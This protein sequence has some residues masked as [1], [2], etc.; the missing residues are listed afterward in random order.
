M[1]VDLGN[2][3]R[4][5]QDLVVD[6]ALGFLEAEANGELVRVEDLSEERAVIRVGGFRYVADRREWWIT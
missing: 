5:L 6:R 2:A 3:P 1:V 4:W